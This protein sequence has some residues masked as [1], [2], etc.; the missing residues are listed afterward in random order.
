MNRKIIISVIFLI[1]IFNAQ[2]SKCYDL[3]VIVVTAPKNEE[4]SFNAK[5]DNFSSVDIITREQLNEKTVS[6]SEIFDNIPGIQLKKYGGL[7]EYATISIRGSSSEQIA[8]LIDG[9]A[10]NDLL[11]GGVNIANI[12]LDTIEKIEVFRGSS[13]FSLGVQAIGGIV[14]IKTLSAKKNG[15][16]SSVTIGSFDYRKLAVNFFKTKNKLSLIAGLQYSSAQNDYK[17]I[18]DNRTHLIKSDD[19]KES[20][21]NNDFAKI[22]ALSKISYSITDLYT[23]KLVFSLNSE[24]KGLAGVFYNQSD[25]AKLKTVQY[26]AQ[27]G[28]TKNNFFSNPGSIELSVHTKL[29]KEN[30]YDPYMEIGWLKRDTNDKT[31]EIGASLIMNAFYNNYSK[32]S[33]NF[34]Y[35]RVKLLPSDAFENNY[36]FTQERDELKISAEQLLI[37]FSERLRIIPGVMYERFNCRKSEQKQNSLLNQQ[38]FLRDSLISR[39]VGINYSVSESVMLKSSAGIFFRAPSMFELFGDRGYTMGNNSLE[40]EKSVN[41]DAGIL[42]KKKIKKFD[43]LAEIIGFHRNVKNLIQWLSYSSQ[44]MY[45][46]NIGRAELYGLESNIKMECSK[47]YFSGAYTYMKT[48]NKEAAIQ[49]LKRELPSK[50]KIDAANE[51]GY[52][53][54]QGI[55]LYIQYNY[56]GESYK[57]I[58]NQ[59]KNDN[60]SCVNTGVTYT[61]KKLQ[62]NFEIK[63]LTDELTQ[64]VYGF[65]LPGRSFYCRVN[66]NF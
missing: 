8:V 61:Y 18:H 59:F 56:T 65:P 48:E 21:K 19:Y 36:F 3:G 39:Q 4:N 35:N 25:F 51:I 63:N 43:V 38:S 17:Y 28:L 55:K 9:I 47:I 5:S 27:A 20:R 13:P 44:I 66:Y 30:F 12:P 49:N 10:I 54:K 15:I 58:D 6:L 31:K 14:N 53:I 41:I 64:D 23:A 37:L 24:D 33:L 45:P 42:V 62:S 46:D 16:E 34:F 11:G 26:S 1:L 57:D 60:K 52:N 32:S 50:P 29:S 2:Q 7:D 22:S 40:Q